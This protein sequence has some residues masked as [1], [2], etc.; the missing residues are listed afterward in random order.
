[1]SWRTVATGDAGTV[2]TLRTM[3]DLVESSS[4]YP[5]VVS[6]AR[7]IVTHEAGGSRDPA[8]IADAAFSWLLR[9]YRYVPDPAGYELISEPL[10]MLDSI[11]REGIV[12]EDCESAATLLA[13]LLEAVGVTTRFHVT[14]HDP[15]GAPGDTGFSHVYV[16]VLTPAGWRAYDPTLTDPR[17]GVRPPA[18][19][20]A[21]YPEG[22][23][24]LY[25]LGQD[26]PDSYGVAIG[27]GD[28][29][30][31]TMPGVVSW[32]NLV[33]GLRDLV[34]TAL[35]ILER[36][37]VLTPVRGPSRLPL[38]GEPTGAYTVSLPEVQKMLP[39]ILLG[40]AALFL[41]TGR[42]R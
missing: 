6:I 5:G 22:S 2:Q 32:E 19:A 38:P 30:T 25:R 7:R 36:Y 29:S 9:H 3:R 33:G 17:P 20:G 26:H 24:M 39:W 37:D 18:V 42:R 41:F 27:E 15:S 10:R 11:A 13:A 28:P 21:V 4:R 8:R 23:T 31:P 40:G 1:M 35:P 16:E 12:E 34:G 14:A